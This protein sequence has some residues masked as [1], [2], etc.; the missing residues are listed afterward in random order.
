MCYYT[1]LKLNTLNPFAQRM[2]EKMEFQNEELAYLIRKEDESLQCSKLQLEEKIEEYN[3]LTKQL[4]SAWK[5]GRK[6]VLMV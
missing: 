1:V 2:L 6:M 4:E 3:S 5:E